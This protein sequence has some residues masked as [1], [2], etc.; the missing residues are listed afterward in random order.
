MKAV[1]IVSILT[2]AVVFTV[3]AYGGY[4]DLAGLDQ[5]EETETAKRNMFQKTPEAVVGAKVYRMI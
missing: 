1:I 4:E 3:D 5:R 2:L